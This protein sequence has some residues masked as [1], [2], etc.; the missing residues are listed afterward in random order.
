MEAAEG[1]AMI[2][3]LDHSRRKVSVKMTRMSRT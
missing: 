2:K 3:A 1:G